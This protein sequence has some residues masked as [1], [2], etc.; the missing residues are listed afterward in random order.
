MTA[1]VL[2]LDGCRRLAR[3]RPVSARALSEANQLCCSAH[4]HQHPQHVDTPASPLIRG[5]SSAKPA[6]INVAAKAQ[7]TRTASMVPC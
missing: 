1:F 5:A 4:E 3:M 7:W 2:L 6:R